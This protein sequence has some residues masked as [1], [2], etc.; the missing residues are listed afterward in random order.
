MAPIERS[1]QALAD[2]FSHVLPEGDFD[3]DVRN[4]FLYKGNVFILDD[5]V[6]NHAINSHLYASAGF[7]QPGLSLILAGHSSVYCQDE[8]LSIP[9]YA[10]L[11]SPASMSLRFETSAQQ[12]TSS[13]H[14]TFNLD[15]LNLVSRAMQGGD[16]QQP[17]KASA[18]KSITLNYGAVNLR[19]MFLNLIQQ[20]DAFGGDPIL[21]K[22]SGF[23]DQIYR[24]LAITLQP[25]VFLKECVDKLSISASSSMHLLQKFEQYVDVNLHLPM[26]LTEIEIHL[27]VSARTLQYACMKAHKCSPRVYIRNKRLGYAFDLVEKNKKQIKL[28]ELAA[29]LHFSSQS[30]F[31]R[32]FKERFGVL[33]SEVIKN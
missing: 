27:G 14:L 9:N 25:D 30:Q 33:P 28:A 20:I 3:S 1:F 12:L 24:L 21:L 26:A 16:A 11:L 4:A 15:R 23:D 17:V 6:V 2:Q 7:Q 5:L 32:Y 29:E 18:L 8:K 10:A 22:T 19:Y 13:L 31:S